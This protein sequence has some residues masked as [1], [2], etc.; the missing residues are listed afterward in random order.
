MEGKTETVMICLR[1]KYFAPNG[2]F[3]F[4]TVSSRNAEGFW[5][6]NKCYVALHKFT[7]LNKLETNELQVVIEIKVTL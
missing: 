1:C 2:V 3:S 4:I 7:L 5:K 6:E